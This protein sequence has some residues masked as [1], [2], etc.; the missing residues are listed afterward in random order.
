M[1]PLNR[2]NYGS[3]PHLS[4]SKL[5]EKDYFIHEG[6]ERILT[7]KKR[8]K[9]D[10]ILVFE[11]YDGSN[12]GIAKKN[13][14]IY[15]LTRSGYE[16]KTSPYKQHHLFSDWVYER[17]NVFSDLLKED[18]RVVG[19][20]LMQTHG[21]IY[22]IEQEPIVFFDYFNAKS[23]RQE[24]EVLKQTGLPLPRILQKGDAISVEELK[25]ILNLKTDTIWSKED[26]EGMIYRVER[27][28]KVD[29]LAKWV[30]SDFEAGKYCI[31][32]DEKEL[33]WNVSS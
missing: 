19:E 30:R 13:G 29:F 23:E 26:P 12:V 10:T 9:H 24:F 22:N 7:Q 11:K 15:A 18:E 5:G 20:W 17:E 2:K 4:N 31:G 27:K 32:V 16:A 25:P 21:L 8:D 3:I 14:K 33:I 28:G 6:Q 1:K